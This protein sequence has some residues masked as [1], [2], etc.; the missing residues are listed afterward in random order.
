MAILFPSLPKPKGFFRKFDVVSSFK[1]RALVYF[2]GSAV[3]CFQALSTQ[4]KAGELDEKATAILK[5]HCAKCHDANFPNRSTDDYSGPLTSI[6][7]PR[8]LFQQKYLIP[9]SAEDSDIYLRLSEGEMPPPGDEPNGRPSE[10]EIATVK[11]WINSISSLEAAK[12]QFLSVESEFAKVRDYLQTIPS[13]ERSF[14]R[15]FSIRQS[16]NNR[17]LYSEDL[18]MLRLALAKS[19]NSLSWQRTL[20]SLNPIDLQQTVYAID[21]RDVGWSIA[22]WDKVTSHYPYGVRYDTSPVDDELNNNAVEVYRRTGTIIPIIRADW[23]ITSA[24][25]PPL[26]HVLLEIPE[27]AEV[28]EKRLGIDAEENIRSGRVA[29]AA[30]LKSGVSAQNR[31]IE[32]HQNGLFGFYWKSY[33][34]KSL[35]E[36]PRSSLIRFPLGPPMKDHPYPE[37]AFQHDGGEL[38]FELPNGL[39]GYMLIDDKGNRIDA[40]P[41]EVVEDKEGRFSGSGDIVNGISCMGC[42]A[43]GMRNMPSDVLRGDTAIQGRPLRLLRKL[44]PGDEVVDNWIKKDRESFQS[45]VLKV[46]KS[47]PSS[48]IDLVTEQG[49]VL[50]PVTSAA[51]TFRETIDL[52]DLAAELEFDDPQKLAIAIENNP[53][54]RRE[55]LA[56]VAKGKPYQ[57]S[58]LEHRPALSSTY[59]R[60]IAGL[61]K[62][63]AAW[64]VA[65]D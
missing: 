48:Q 41:R 39:Q 33:D 5:K 1:T 62:G 6:L 57:R 49:S 7:N 24:T 8:A 11:E 59:Q 56:P 18:D 2:L 58:T 44:H 15:F 35:K 28:L 13:D 20:V 9:K 31:M 32:R 23:F 63:S 51:K 14:V 42:H 4:T 29:R 36:S 30:T 34:F 55:G 19:I 46:M 43:N 16:H 21:L 37:F 47:V 25:A 50:E 61:G 27:T 53:E 60:I 52:N 26:Y 64:V 3:I 12:R 38:I 45:A 22:T 54:L 40:G 65:S 17:D 10:D